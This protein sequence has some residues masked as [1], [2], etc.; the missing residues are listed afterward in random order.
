MV[1]RSLLAECLLPSAMSQN[2]TTRFTRKGP[3]I[4]SEELA[5]VMFGN[6]A[7][8]FKPLFATVYAN[9]RARKIANGGEEMLRL[10]VYEKLQALVGRGMVN[11]TITAGVK[12]YLGLA[13]LSLALPLPPIL[14]VVA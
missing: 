3:D 12:E 6:A 10:R 1:Q 2:Y 4:L 13:S 9:L 7:L 14:P 11:K 8:E 5:T